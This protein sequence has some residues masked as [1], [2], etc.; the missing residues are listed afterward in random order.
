MEPVVIARGEV[1]RAAALGRAVGPSIRAGSRV[2]GLV[3]LAGAFGTAGVALAQ[4]KGTSALGTARSDG[5][6]A[7]T[8]LTR[9]AASPPRTASAT[10][11]PTSPPAG[12]KPPPAAPPA[13]ADT[14]SHAEVKRFHVRDEWGDCVVARLYGEAD[15]RTAVLQPDGQIGFPRMLVPTRDPFVPM[16][17]DQLQR[18]LE[19][20]PF[21]GFGVI[22]TPHYLVFY[23][24]RLAF[25]QDSAKLLEELYHGLVEFCG[26]NEIPV[27]ESEFPLVAVIFATED[28]F[29]AHKDIDPEVQA[30]YEIFTNRIFFYEQSARDRNEPKLVALRKPQTVAHEGT[31]QILANIGVQPRLA[32]WPLWLIEGFAEYCATPTR[33]KSGL[34]FKTLGNI[35]PL[36]MA[37]LRELD[38]PLSGVPMDDEARAK[39]AARPSRLLDS[40][41]LLTKT[42]L[43]PTDY[44]Q[45]WA[46]TSYLARRRSTEFREYLRA[47]GRMAPLQRKAPEHKLAEFRKFFGDEPAKLDKKVEEYVRKLSQSR[48]FESLPYFAVIFEQPLG[49]G[50]VHR[51]A[52]VTQS[53][54]MIQRWVEQTIAPQGGMFTW[55]AYP[56]PTKARAEIAAENWIRGY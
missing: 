43:T 38:D 21:A 33:T 47:M 12:V 48:R 31:H 3:V 35:N 10:S 22:A 42:Q 5:G 19:K 15:D 39:A 56:F 6:S 50:R 20:K 18:R 16:T 49:G 30:Y 34:S 29:R 17:A 4:G 7:R 28:D 2:L 13:H 23:Q 37:T 51:K 54:Q 52:W 27:H 1:S 32:D 14:A 44:A 55:D 45:S 40:E 46:L 24:S 41:A 53:P 26:R 9:D 11:R 8:T 25:A 36:H